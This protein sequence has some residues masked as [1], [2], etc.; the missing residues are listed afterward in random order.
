MLTVAGGSSIEST[1]F[2]KLS[3]EIPTLSITSTEPLYRIILSFITS[4]QVR[5]LTGLIQPKRSSPKIQNDTCA[6]NFKENRIFVLQISKENIVDYDC[7]IEF[8][9]ILGRTELEGG[10]YLFWT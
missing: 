2:T 3:R 5:A 9:F 1:L 10:F 6:P 8:L 7:G 4:C